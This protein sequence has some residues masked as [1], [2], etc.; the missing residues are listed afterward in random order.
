MIASLALALCAAS[1]IEL[2]LGAGMGRIVGE[3]EAALGRDSRAIDAI[4]EPTTWDGWVGYEWSPGHVLGM[5]YQAWNASGR[6]EAMDDLGE[7]VQEELDL[8]AWGFEYTRILGSAPL[9][10]RVGGGLG[11]ADATDRLEFATEDLEA[12]GSGWTVWGRGGVQ[13]PAGPLRFHVDAVTS[14]M[15]FSRMKPKGQEPYKST[16][17]ILHLE[18]ALSYRI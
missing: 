13:L 4:R 18:A 16:Y 12:K 14:W 9:R 2:G 6:V 11:F 3:G 15:S 1:G 7:D 5:R 8:T 17:P 10:W